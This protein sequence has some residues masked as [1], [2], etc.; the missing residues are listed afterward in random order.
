[1]Q[2]GD[3]TAILSAFRPYTILKPMTTKKVYKI[4]LVRFGRIWKMSQFR[5]IDKVEGIVHYME[6]TLVYD[7]HFAHNTISLTSNLYWGQRPNWN[8]LAGSCKNQIYVV[9]SSLWPRSFYTA[10]GDNM[11]L[12][13]ENQFHIYKFL[14]NVNK[15]LKSADF[16]A[17]IWKFGP[18]YKT[19]VVTYGLKWPKIALNLDLISSARRPKS[20]LSS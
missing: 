12:N 8:P 17:E 20:T 2:Y 6:V 11:I 15:Q 16:L 1:M 4:A 14:K 19:K 9:K 10:P 13:Y 5:Y 18:V 7:H 3:R